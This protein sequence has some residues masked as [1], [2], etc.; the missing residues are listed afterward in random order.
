M[1]EFDDSFVSR[2]PVCAG[3]VLVKSHEIQCMNCDWT[4]PRNHEVAIQCESR[5][6][7]GAL[8]SPPSCRK[9]H[10]RERKGEGKDERKGE[11]K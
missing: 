3:F 6:L 2:C 8:F 9:P 4:S 5:N 1:S 7:G 11:G 10:P